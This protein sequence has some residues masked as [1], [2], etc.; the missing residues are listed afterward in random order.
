MR[1]NR[2]LRRSPPL[3]HGFLRGQK[4]RP[5]CSE[6][7]AEDTSCSSCDCFSPD[8]TVT[9]VDGTTARIDAVTEDDAILATTSDGS[10]S[11]G[12]VSFLRTS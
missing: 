10:L 9:K 11:S 1:Q 4:R 6:C 7:G 8:A 3:L 12:S 2:W 5:N